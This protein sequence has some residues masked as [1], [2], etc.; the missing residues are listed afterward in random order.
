MAHVAGGE[1][2]SQEAEVSRIRL[3]IA[4]RVQGVGFR[5]YLHS[6]AHQLGLSGYARNESDSVVVEVQGDTGL[7]KAFCERLVTGAPALARIDRIEHERVSVQEHPGFV[8]RQSH[9]RCTR[10]I[11][12]P[13]DMASCQECLQDT[14]TLGDR[15]HVYPFTNCTQCGPR[16]TIISDIP[17]DRRNTSM[18]GFVPCPLCY[19]SYSNPADRR[20][21]AQPVACRACGPQVEV[22]DRNGGL[23][24]GKDEWQ[25]FCWE[26][27]L[28]GDIIAVKGLGGF[29]L[30]CILSEPVI[31]K[32]RRRK[33]RPCKPLAVMCRS[34]E[35]V[36]EFCLASQEELAVLTSPRSPIV[37]LRKR[38]GAPL[39]V[40]V[41]PGLET[42]GVMLPCTPLHHLLLQ[43]PFDIMVLTSGNVSDFPLART[44]AEAAA[45]LHSIA[46]YFLWHN[47]EILQR[48]D[49]SVVQV[50]DGD[51]QLIR[52]ARGFVPDSIPLGFRADVS[53]LG[54][55][56]DMKN[57]FCL[58]DADQAVLSQHLGE[59]GTIEA[60]D[61][62]REALHHFLRLSGCGPKI[63][64]YDL[65]PDYGVS[66]LVD[67]MGIPWRYAVQHHHAHFASCLA[68]NRHQGPAIGVILDGTGYGSDG[69]IWG[70]EVITGDYVE[71]ERRYHLRYLPLL[72]GEGSIRW[73]WR[74]AVSYLRQAYG[75]DGIAIAESLFGREYAL[76]LRVLASEARQLANSPPNSSCGRLFDAVSALL[77]VASEN[78]YDGQAAIELSELVRD[79]D[80]ESALD[81]YPFEIGEREIDFSATIRAICDALR[82][83][84]DVVL[85]ARR[86]HDTVAAA[87]AKAVLRIARDSGLRTIALSGGVWQNAYLARR[88]KLM[89]KGYAV[90]CHKAV[91]PNDGGLSLGQAAVAYWRWQRDHVSRGT[92]ESGGREQR[93][94]RKS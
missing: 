34:R 55:G 13:P 50:I 91:P 82:S 12:I 62:F 16:F 32:L 39:P 23:V 90:L 63:L 71:F 46:D 29:Q 54:L 22:R 56:G 76:P 7:L 40:N 20:F 18:A 33:R 94:D 1:L 59:M 75:P 60:G 89:L 10:S 45:S 78:T 52:R 28:Q 65:H 69:A 19:S 86:F 44:N 80:P 85:M 79:A 93:F 83:R 48:C 21:H 74:M 87:V 72:G 26:R 43:G 6:L 64:G 27:M 57:T 3:R 66:S 11:L 77:G 37:L 47:R 15:H 9:E 84:D 17:Y 53:V 2:D 58:I 4:G 5:P 49:D 31:A 38:A 36:A 81:P 14:Q 8:I 25:D 41:S 68:E 24:A 67:D 88:V 35:T 30:A 42:L 92:H 61:A 73:P 70:F 51:P